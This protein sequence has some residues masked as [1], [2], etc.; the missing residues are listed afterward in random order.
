MI[1][2]G[3]APLELPPPI[4]R[5]ARVALDSSLSLPIAI[6]V[7]MP[8]TASPVIEFPVLVFAPPAARWKKIGRPLASA[9]AHSG[10]YSSA[11]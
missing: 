8:L 4:V 2:I 9:Q 5:A 11:W 3:T 7:S 6:A 1:R 10:S